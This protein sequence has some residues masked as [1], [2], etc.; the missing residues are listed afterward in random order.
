[1]EG[2]KFA[3]T[4]GC[5]SEVIVLYKWSLLPTFH[6]SGKDADDITS[7]NKFLKPEIDFVRCA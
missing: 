5:T 1:M 4:D 3:K 7:K 2:R 6:A